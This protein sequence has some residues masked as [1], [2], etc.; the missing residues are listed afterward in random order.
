MLA[1]G[2]EPV[3]NRYD[4]ARSDR[5][6]NPL[7]VNRLNPVRLHDSDMGQETLS[8]EELSELRAEYGRKVNR[9]LPE[10]AQSGDGWPIHLD[11]CFG[12]VVLD[13]L[14]GDEWYSHVDGRPAY[15][16][17]TRDEL[18]EAIEIADRM[19]QGGKPVVEELN[20]NSLRWRE[21]LCR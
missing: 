20:E 6:D 16:N 14:F 18:Q 7:Q 5:C 10:K 21:E 9:E 15:R 13:N 12:R 17:L 3:G 4:P 8:G 2:T 11:H 1:D 19:I